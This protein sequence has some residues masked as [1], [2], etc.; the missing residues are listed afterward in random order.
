MPKAVLYLS[1][2]IDSNIVTEVG[3]CS[4]S[5]IILIAIVM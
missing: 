4:V 1:N 5:L 3:K 2:D